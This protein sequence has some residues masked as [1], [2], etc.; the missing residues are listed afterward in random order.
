MID[1]KEKAD[2]ERITKICKVVAI[3]DLTLA[4]ISATLGDKVFVLFMLLAGGMWAYGN[5]LS[6][7]SGGEENAE[8]E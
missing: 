5:F 2:L 8:H 7:L 1:P 3:L 6:K 4:F